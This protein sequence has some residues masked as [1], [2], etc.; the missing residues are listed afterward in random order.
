MKEIYN[1][2]RKMFLTAITT[3][4]CCTGFNTSA[5]T[6]HT[7]ITYLPFINSLTDTTEVV[8]SDY[9]IKHA[10]AFE[11][12]PP[13]PKHIFLYWVGKT[14][15]I[16]YAGDLVTETDT[17]YA[18]WNDTWE[19]WNWED[20]AQVIVKQTAGFTKFKLMQDLGD[21]NKTARFDVPNPAC[22]YIDVEKRRGGYGYDTYV[23][24]VSDLNGSGW[25]P[26]RTF[27]SEFN[28]NKKTINDLWIHR[29][30]HGIGLFGETYTAFIH[31]LGINLSDKGIVANGMCAPY[32][33]YTPNGVYYVGTGALV[34]QAN[35]TTMESCYATGPVTGGYCVGGLAGALY[36]GYGPACHIKD[37]YAVGPVKGASSVGGFVGFMNNSQTATINCYSLGS[38]EVPSDWPSTGEPPGS[39][40]AN[41]G[42][43][44]GSTWGNWGI[45]NCVAISETSTLTYGFTSAPGVPVYT[46]WPKTITAAEAYNINTYNNTKVTTSDW[47]SWEINSP[48]SEW[49]MVDG[50]TFPYLKWQAERG[51]SNTYDVSCVIYTVNGGASNTYGPYGPVTIATQGSSVV[52]T[53]Q[54]DNADRIYNPY[55]LSVLFAGESASLAAYSTIQ[56]T[57]NLVI[58][59]MS[60]SDIIGVWSPCESN[61]TI[62]YLSGTGTG[63]DTTE[64]VS[65]GYTIKTPADLNFTAP[66]G[67]GFLYWLGKSD[68]IYNIG[69]IVTYT[70]TLIAQWSDIWEIWNWDDLSRVPEKQAGGVR[71]FKIMQDIGVPGSTPANYGDGSG[72]DG[73]T[74]PYYNDATTSRRYGWYGYRGYNGLTEAGYTSYTPTTGTVH[75]W[76]NVSGWVPYSIGINVNSIEILF[77][78]NNKTISGLTIVSGR[79]AGLFMYLYEDVTLQSLNLK[80]INIDL[81]SGDGLPDHRAGG[82]AY[83]VRPGATISKCNVISGNIDAQSGTDNRGIVG[84]ITAINE[85]TVYRC[86]NNATLAQRRLVSMTGGIAGYNYG[87]NGLIDECYNTGTMGDYSSTGYMAGLVSVNGNAGAYNGAILRKSFNAAGIRGYSGA[88]GIAYQVQGDNTKVIDCYNIG[89][90][91]GNNQ[92]SNMFRGIYDGAEIIRC[93]SSGATNSNIG[94]RVINGIMRDAKLI[95]CYFDKNTSHSIPASGI[96]TATDVN[97]LE[98][99]PLVTSEMIDGTTINWFTQPNTAW[100]IIPGCTYPY[101]AWQEEIA[102][103]L[104]GS[105]FKITYNVNGGDFEPLPIGISLPGSTSYRIKV[106]NTSTEPI[107]IFN[108]YYSPYMYVAPGKQYMERDMPRVIVPANDEKTDTIYI[109]VG[110]N[111]TTD[112][113]NVSIGIVSNAMLVWFASSPLLTISGRL[114]AAPGTPELTAAHF[115]D[116]TKVYTIDD[117]L[118]PTVEVQPDG[119]YVIQNIPVGA[120]VAITPPDIAGRITPAATFIAPLMQDSINHDFEYDIASQSIILDIAL[121][122]QGVVQPDSTM[123]NHI[124]TAPAIIMPNLKLPVVNPYS[125]ADSCSNINSVVTIGEI[126]DWVL[127]EIWGEFTVSGMFTNYTLLEQRALLLKTDGSVVD[128]NGQKPQ[129][130]LN[131]NDSVRVVVK[132]RNHLS[133]VSNALFPFDENIIYDFST[134]VSKALKPPLAI[135]DPMVVMYDGIACLWAGDLNMNDIMDHVDMSIFN[136]EWRAGTLGEYLTSDVNMDGRINNVDNS[137][138]ARNTQLGLYSPVFFFIKR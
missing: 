101:L 136:V 107:G 105:S 14:D 132:H 26:L 12:T 23:D 32:S 129:L 44:L 64:V 55:G 74:S 117:V 29:N 18:F 138:V 94:N 36:T 86:W 63:S 48:T 34:G 87:P 15:K 1:P 42:S 114:K 22:P 81:P 68:K 104:G 127:V 49:A 67:Q 37:C 133:V 89:S 45:E 76:N 111:V 65:L 10:N 35:F 103:V 80:D 106:E 16:Y 50:K 71:N 84:G 56:N 21:P 62:T 11:F 119:T 75:G 125:L 59:F 58:G 60:E 82:F 112:P 116:K 6:T 77:D 61:Y 122:L 30:G 96:G 115:V 17:V 124:Q 85:G 33:W 134:D 100:K 9:T 5:Q 72:T 97:V 4:L 53:A 88:S 126:V 3:L 70:D 38:V 130:M 128:T 102:N 79:Y 98:L 83:W 40:K 90:V 73:H 27:R 108:N 51:L 13:T 41:M 8:G 57:Q 93:Y 54:N 28:G 7:L 92:I 66:A 39:G 95:D 47:V 52:F 121:F 113:Q 20:L 137:F 46:N 131:T 135:Y 69:D 43:Y 91:L 2:F 19:I 110:H 31:H 78:G 25:I 118:H 24:N 120:T 99:T 123:T 109:P